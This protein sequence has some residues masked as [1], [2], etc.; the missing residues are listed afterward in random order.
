ML[1]VVCV[2]MLSLFHFRQINEEVSKLFKSVF[3]GKFPS[4]IF[5]N[6]LCFLCCCCFFFGWEKEMTKKNNALTFN[7]IYFIFHISQMLPYLCFPKS[8]VWWCMRYINQTQKWKLNLMENLL[9][10]VFYTEFSLWKI[11]WKKQEKDEIKFPY[12]TMMC[13]NT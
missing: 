11:I 13:M 12:H 7:V 6:F 9:L 4:M 2:T 10:V 8:H 5:V 1:Y 3:E